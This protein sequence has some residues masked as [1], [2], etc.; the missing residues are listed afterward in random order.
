MKEWANLVKPPLHGADWSRLGTANFLSNRMST[1]DHLGDEKVHNLHN[2][3]PASKK[4]TSRGQDLVTMGADKVLEI[5]KSEISKTL[6]V[7]TKSQ[8]V[9]ALLRRM[10]ECNAAQRNHS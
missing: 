4:L 3:I 7:T 10:N 6:R 1:K 5:C 8:V 9:S 2:Y